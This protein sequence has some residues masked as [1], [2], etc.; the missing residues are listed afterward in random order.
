MATCCAIADGV[1]LGRSTRRWGVEDVDKGAAEA[2]Y[3]EMLGH[4]G[5]KEGKKVKWLVRKTV[6]TYILIQILESYELLRWREYMLSLN[7]CR[8][9]LA[10]DAKTG[11]D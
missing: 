11:S 2:G 6:L 8:R 5:L 4:D 3:L 7:I 10:S 9:R 1:F